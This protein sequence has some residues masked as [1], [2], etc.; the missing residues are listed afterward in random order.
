MER[1]MKRLTWVLLVVAA[2]ACSGGQAGGG[3]ATQQQGGA[4]ATAQDTTH[5]MSDSAMKA[6][7]DTAKKDTVKKQ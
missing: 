4:A 3:A 6:M 2:A 1:E 5:A 7:G